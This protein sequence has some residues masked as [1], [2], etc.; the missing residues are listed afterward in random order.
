VAAD[1]TPFDPE[2]AVAVTGELEALGGVLRR[3]LCRC[4][5]TRAGQRAEGAQPAEHDQS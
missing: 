3:D 4:L 2:D 5:T 1:I